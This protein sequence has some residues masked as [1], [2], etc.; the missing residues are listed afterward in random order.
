MT[1]L[2]SLELQN[3]IKNMKVDIYANKITLPI[4]LQKVK[5]VVRKVK[6]R[7]S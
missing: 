3:S 1:A 2:R 5:L 6:S 4:I 7:K